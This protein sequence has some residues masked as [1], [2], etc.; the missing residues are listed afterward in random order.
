[1]GMEWHAG[2]ESLSAGAV[3][4]S[5]ASWTLVLSV[6]LPILGAG[7]LLL[8]VAWRWGRLYCGWLCPHFSA[9]ETINMLMRR[10]SGKF[11]VWDT[12]RLPSRNPDGTSTRTSPVWW[13]V[14]VTVAV[15]FAFVWSVV[16]LTYLWSPL[17][18]YRG[19][20]QVELSRSQFIFLL[21]GTVA[22]SVEFLFA[23]HLFCQFACAVGIFQSI[24]WMSNRKAMVVGFARD[25]ARDCS[26]CYSACDHVCP[27][28]LRPRNIKRFIFSCA[29]CS[30]CIDAC[31]IVQKSNPNGGLLSWVEGER[32]EEH[33][34]SMHSRGKQTAH[35]RTPD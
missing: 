8:Y 27:M 7:A 18:V 5:R 24:A 13:A 16:F 26:S 12:R 25:R 3:S 4:A 35:A 20:L 2:L 23:R 34:A 19:L 6:F 15:A 22:L 17:D 30:Q 29:Q 14:T 31:S 33:E 28:R 1:M 9:V 11:S 32:A 21:S 10:A